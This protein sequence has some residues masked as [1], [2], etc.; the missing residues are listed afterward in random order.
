VIWD[1]NI[2]F[3]EPNVVVR[4]T[5]TAEII[6]GLFPCRAA[7]SLLDHRIEIEKPCPTTF[8]VFELDQGH[9][10]AFDFDFPVVRFEIVI[11]NYNEHSIAEPYKP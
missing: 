9:R 1:K 5:S 4:K 3:N 2:V 6:Q 10:V 8:V 7:T 11:V